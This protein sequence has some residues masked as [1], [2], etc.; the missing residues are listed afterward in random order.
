MSIFKEVLGIDLGTSSVIIYAQGR[1]IVLEEPSVVA[2]DEN[3]KIMAVGNAAR[4]MLG[5]TPDMVQALR[6]IVGG[7]INDY[8][9]AEAMIKYFINKVVSKYLVMKPEIMVS[10]PSSISSTE[11]RAVMEVVLR[12]GA[13][14]VFVVREPVLSAVGSGVPIHEPKGRMVVN[15]G[16]GTTDVAVVSLGG[17]VVSKSVKQTAKQAEHTKDQKSNAA[18]TKHL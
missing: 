6:P 11:R 2:V 9:G 1:G 8:A 17:V 13:K 15:I 10:V 7:V 12:A 16:A 4:E 5:K 18:Y 3:K 14:E